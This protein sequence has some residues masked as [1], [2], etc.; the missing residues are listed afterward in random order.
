[1]EFGL[2]FEPEMVN[3]DSDLFRTHP[4]WIL[5]V[6]DYSQPLGRYQ[7]VLNLAIPEAYA[8]IHQCIYGLLSQNKISYVKWDM[9]RH[10]SDLYSAVTAGGELPHRYMLGLYEVLEALTVRFPNILFENCS[11]GGGRFDPGMLYYSPQIWCSDNTS[12]AGKK[13]ELL[14]RGGT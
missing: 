2:W 14:A 10:M 13:T 9:N 6:Q 8:Y 11:G 4:E 5:Q 7:Y 12:L 1:M 3:P